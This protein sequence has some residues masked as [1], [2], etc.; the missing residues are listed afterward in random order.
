MKTT[1]SKNK[2]FLLI[3]LA[4]CVFAKAQNNWTFPMIFTIGSGI[5]DTVWFIQDDNATL[6]VDEEF[7]EGQFEI[8]PDVF[9]VYFVLENGMLSKVIAIPFTTDFTNILV[10][11]T[12]WD[13]PLTV[14]WNKELFDTIVGNYPPITHATLENLY[15]GD[16]DLEGN[17]IYD[18]YGWSILN[19]NSTGPQPPY[20]EHDEQNWSWFNAL[21]AGCYFPMKVNLLRQHNSIIETVGESLSLDV[22]P[23]PAKDNTYLSLMSTQQQNIEILLK[24]LSGKIVKKIFNGTVSQGEQTMFLETNDMPSGCYILEVLSAEKHQHIKIIITE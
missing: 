5:S 9:Q 11:A 15:S 8:N 12:N 17:L 13:F 23:N 18:Y 24:D 16:H 2:L 4:C 19:I 22:Y 3:L 20:D 10:R 1:L 14:S 7:G 21:Y 6:G